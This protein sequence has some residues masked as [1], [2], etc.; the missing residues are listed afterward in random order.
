MAAAMLAV[1]N[2]TVIAFTLVWE[3]ALL[4]QALLRGAEDRPAPTGAPR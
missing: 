4:R 1:K 3:L 2:P